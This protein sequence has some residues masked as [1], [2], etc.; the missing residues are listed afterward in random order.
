M[1]KK[2]GELPERFKRMHKGYFR[3]CIAVNLLALAAVPFI[4]VQLTAHQNY[5]DD[6][7]KAIAFI[8][9]LLGLAFY[10]SMIYW[11]FIRFYLWIYDGFQK[12]KKHDVIN[13]DSGRDNRN[14]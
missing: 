13:L 6:N 1:K 14:N 7:E 4:T 10:G 8:C 11:L 2:W 5:D 3:L 12:D 9:A